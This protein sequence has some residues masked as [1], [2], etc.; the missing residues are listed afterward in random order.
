ME[1]DH[2]G[3][4]LHPSVF[5]EIARRFGMPNVDLFASLANA[6]VSRFFV[7]FP[8][9]RAEGVDALRSPWPRGLLYAFPPTPLL[10]RVIRK[11]IAERAQVLL[12]APFWPRRPWFADLQSLSLGRPWRIPQDEIVLLQGSLEHPEARWLQLTVWRLSGS[13]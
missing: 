4:S 1:V 9:L 8:A 12:M 6:Q 3:W 2:A 7:R 13:L 10:P 5:Q 11:V